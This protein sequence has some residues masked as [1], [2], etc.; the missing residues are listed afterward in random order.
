MSEEELSALTIDLTDDVYNLD[1]QV[2]DEDL[3]EI[4]DERFDNIT[5]HELVEICT[6][7]SDPSAN[8]IENESYV[9]QKV[10][11]FVKDSRC[12]Q[13]KVCSFLA[14]IQS[15]FCSFYQSVKIKKK[16][17]RLS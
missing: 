17:E 12:E 2:D 7:L 10:L 11:D 14:T 16:Q 3:Q 4:T 8:Y 6:R 15:S 1:L 13:D 5:K 9:A